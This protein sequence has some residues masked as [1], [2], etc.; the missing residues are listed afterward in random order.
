RFTVRDD[1]PRFLRAT[2]GAVG[3]LLAV[4]MARLLRHAEADPTAPTPDELERARRIAS[5]SP[6]SSAN[7]ALL[8]D[9]TLLFAEGDGGFLMYGVEGRSWVALGD[10]VGPPETRGELAWRFR[11]EADRHGA[12]PVFYQV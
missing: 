4:G 11:E 1:A 9:K 2:A 5:R 3:V 10:P 6:E 8:G 7:L 12:W